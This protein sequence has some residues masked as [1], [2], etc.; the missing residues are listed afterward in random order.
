MT[1][2]IEENS[3][4]EENRLFLRRAVKTETLR[5]YDRLWNK[6]IEFEKRIR[7]ESTIRLDDEA[8]TIHYIR[9]LTEEDNRRFDYVKDA[10][11]AIRHGRITRGWGVVHLDSAAVGMAK[12]ASRNA[13]P[14]RQRNWETEER[15]KLPITK[16]MIEWLRNESWSKGVDDRMAYLGVVLGFHFMLRISEFAFTTKQ[17]DDHRFRVEDV[18]YYGEDGRQVKREGKVANVTIM[19]RTGKTNR[20]EKIH[21]LTLCRSSRAETQLLEDFVAFAQE[22]QASRTDPFFSRVKD[23]RSKMLTS[24][25]ITD[26]TK[27]M[28]RN[29]EL[30]PKNFT[31]RSLRKGGCTSLRRAGMDPEVIRRVGGWAPDSEVMDTCYALSVGGDRGALRED[32]PQ[33]QLADLRRLDRGSSRREGGSFK[34]S[35]GDSSTGGGQ[36]QLG[37]KINKC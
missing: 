4:L 33:V 24:R 26:K 30:N 18:F 9:W 6:W 32:G 28:A 10:L 5:K 19:K 20:G 7:R 8:I 17:A 34:S 11:A 3:L 1:C 31:T 16:E 25:M 22:S 14:D 13:V 35:R 23:G 15:E 27:L 37:G 29:F 2:L 12:A 36:T 21:R